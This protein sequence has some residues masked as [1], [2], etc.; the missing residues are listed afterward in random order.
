M[1]ER[2]LVVSGPAVQ[3]EGGE[4]VMRPGGVEPMI[5]PRTVNS[6]ELLGQEA[7]T[8]EVVGYS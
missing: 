7:Q 8:R 4:G 6:T 3:L 2:L 1:Q 5:A